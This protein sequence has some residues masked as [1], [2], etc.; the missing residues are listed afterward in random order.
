MNLYPVLQTHVVPEI[1]KLLKLS[2][3]RQVDT[4][5]IFVAETQPITLVQTSVITQKPAE[6]IHEEPLALNM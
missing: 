5:L 1:M 2:Q 3:K 6:Q 4:L